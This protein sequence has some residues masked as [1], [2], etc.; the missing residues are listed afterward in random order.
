MVSGIFKNMGLA[1]VEK[2]LEFIEKRGEVIASNIA[3]ADTPFYRAGRV[4]FEEALQEA[5]YSDRLKLE[6]T[7]EKHIINVKDLDEVEPSF[8]RKL[9]PVRN[10][11]NTVNID[12]EM[13]EYAK[14]HLKHIALTN[15]YFFTISML[16]YA[17]MG[18]RR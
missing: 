12:E 17:I 18:G 8:Y 4:S 3:N 15:S 2:S 14:T 7:S 10:D 1:V 6:V 9:Y 11:M 13:A 5:I 16:K